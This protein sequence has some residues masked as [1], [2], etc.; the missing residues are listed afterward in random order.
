LLTQHR[1]SE[2]T[3]ESNLQMLTSIWRIGPLKDMENYMPGVRSKVNTCEEIDGDIPMHD[4][5]FLFSSSV[6][7]SQLKDKAMGG[8]MRIFLLGNTEYSTF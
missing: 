6:K 3:L 5:R 7:G 1:L 2:E 4:Q 8:W